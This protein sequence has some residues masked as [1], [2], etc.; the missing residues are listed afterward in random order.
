MSDEILAGSIKAVQQSGLRISDDISL[1]GIST[2]FIPSLFEPEISY[3][4]TDGVSLGRK[5]FEILHR[6]L[7]GNPPV[8]EWTVNVRL[9]PG[10][11]LGR[12]V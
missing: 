4:Q 7:S 5:S 11:S 2:G 6:C 10:A 8:G 12:K 9:V 1:I 3:I